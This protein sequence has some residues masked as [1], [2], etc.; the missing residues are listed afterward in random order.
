MAG[1]GFFS[2]AQ[3]LFLAGTGYADNA[4]LGFPTGANA[5]PVAPAFVAS[6]AILV[7]G[8]NAFM[9]VADLSGTYNL[10]VDHCDPTT[11]VAIVTA[12]S[13]A[14]IPGTGSTTTPTMFGAFSS[15]FSGNTTGNVFMV[16]KINLQGNGAART[17]TSI[18]LWCGTR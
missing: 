16:I 2:I 8:F 7:S 13:R 3:P 17:L 10:I 14:G 1:A 12:G 11:D 4:E 5:I 6:N 18:R 15:G 9:V